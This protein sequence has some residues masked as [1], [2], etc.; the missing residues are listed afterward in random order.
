MFAMFF[1]ALGDAFRTGTHKAMILDYLQQNDISH[2]KTHYYG[3]TRSWSQR[4]SAISALLGGALVLIGNDFSVI[5]IV[6]VIPYVFNF[7]NILSY[8][9]NLDGPVKKS[10]KN[11]F[12]LKEFSK[13]FKNRDYRNRV[14]NSASFDSL[15]KTVKDY[16]QP[17]INH[18][19]LLIPVGFAIS[20]TQKSTI[21]ISVIYFFIFFLNAIAS[22]YAGVISGKFKHISKAINITFVTGC[23]IAIVSGVTF[24]LNIPAITLIL[25]ILLYVY[26]NVRRPMNISYISETIPDKFLA[27]GLSVESQTRTFLVAVLSPVMG[28]LADVFGIGWAISSLAVIILLFYPVIKVRK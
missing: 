24:E 1:F 16:I 11:K 9:E 4:G 8:P 19:A 10:K 17:I 6:S 20:D 3:R 18:F 12:S 26:Q 14:I 27:G 13:I 25:F 7:V 15:F 2:L 21:A 23:V 5:F 28:L 22:R